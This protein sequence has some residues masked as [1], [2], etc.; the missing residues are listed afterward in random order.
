MNPYLN[1]ALA[2]GIAPAITVT[3]PQTAKEGNHYLGDE[4][5]VLTQ[6]QPT[7]TKRTFSGTKK[8]IPMSITSI[9]ANAACSENALAVAISVKPH[10]S[11][12]RANAPSSKK[13]TESNMPDINTA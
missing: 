6:K 1:T 9:E 7:A 3:S 11:R 5:Q 10:T 12:L 8:L 2:H 4:L 13:P